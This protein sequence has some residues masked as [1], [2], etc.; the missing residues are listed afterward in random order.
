[1]GINDKVGDRD[2]AREITVASMSVVVTLIPE[3]DHHLPMTHP[4]ICRG[5]L[6][7]PAADP[8]GA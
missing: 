3:A 8:S 6:T 4:E 1:M 5:Q 7:A 2:H